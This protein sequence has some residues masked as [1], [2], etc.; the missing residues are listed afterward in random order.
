MT[1]HLTWL[2]TL[3]IACGVGVCSADGGD[4]PLAGA[5]A[6]AGDKSD[7]QVIYGTF[8]SDP[9]HLFARGGGWMVTGPD[10]Q[11]RNRIAVGEPFIPATD[12]VVRQIDIALGW[13]MDTDAF[14][15]TLRSDNGNKPGDPLAQWKLTDLPQK[16]SVL[17]LHVNRG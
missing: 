7:L 6:S 17:R 5:G 9:K 3:A 10:S 4:S 13:Q 2:A 1:K 8:S 16:R 14:T 12:T 11:A 15:V